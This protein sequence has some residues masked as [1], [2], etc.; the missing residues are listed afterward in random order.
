MVW[1]GVQ[2]LLQMYTH[3]SAACVTECCR[4]VGWCAVSFTNVYTY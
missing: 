1:D 3:T 4:G 2:C